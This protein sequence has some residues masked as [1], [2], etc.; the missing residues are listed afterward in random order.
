MAASLFSPAG[1][2][3]GFGG[4]YGDAVSGNGMPAETDEQKKRR[5]QQLA[6]SQNKISGT[7][8]PAGQALFGFSSTGT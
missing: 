7:L 1:Q 3:L 5:L 4:S 2:A 8:S 6:M